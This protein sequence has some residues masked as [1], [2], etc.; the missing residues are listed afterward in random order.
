MPPHHVLKFVV[1]N[2]D[3]TQIRALIWGTRAARKWEQEI[4]LGSIIQMLGGNIRAV[5]A[6]YRDPNCLNV[7]F[8]VQNHTD[9]TLHGF[10]TMSE[11]AVVEEVVERVPFDDLMDQPGVIVGK[12]KYYSTRKLFF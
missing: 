11:D 10:H 6:R 4:K 8:H 2:A 5:N 1:R 9:I 7:E 12:N 3:G